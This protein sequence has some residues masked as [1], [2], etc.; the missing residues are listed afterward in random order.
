[1]RERERE[2]EREKDLK[3]YLG[4]GREYLLKGKAQYV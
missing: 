1:V 2:R 4:M 3:K